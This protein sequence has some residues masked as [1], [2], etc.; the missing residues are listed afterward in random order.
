[1]ADSPESGLPAISTAMPWQ[2]ESWARLGEQF[3]QKR[4]PHALLLG[5]AAYSGKA[6]FAMALARLLL[7]HQPRDGL[8]CGECHACELSRAGTHGDLRWVAPEEGKQQIKIDYIRDAIA[9]SGHTAGLGERKVI[10]ITPA[11]A[12]NRNSANAL[13]KCLEEPAENTHLMLLSS[14]P[15]RL[16]PTVRSRCQQ[17]TLSQPTPEQSLAWLD[18]T[19]GERSQS[20]RL[21]GLAGNQPLLA[22]ELWANPELE[23]LVALP[24]MLAALIGGRGERRKVVQ[25]AKDLSPAE[26]L[27]QVVRFLQSHAQS[28]SAEALASPRG[29]VLFQLLDD[30][31]GQRRAFAAGANPNRELFIENLLLMLETRLGPA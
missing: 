27:A 30:C 13:L 4:L 2:G 5:G 20:E 31:I 10:V 19:T 17:H 7:C 29:R 6:R 1:M 3:S 23:S 8:N 15:V 26:F 11:E 9:F 24:E 28:L 25:A 18:L 12:M 21:L 22:A 14:S 16:L